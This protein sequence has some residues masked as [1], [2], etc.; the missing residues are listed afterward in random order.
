MKRDWDLIKDILEQVEA[1]TLSDY[2]RQ[3]KYL[4]SVENPD[5]F[6]GHIEILI[7][8]GI[9]KNCRVER[10]DS[11]KFEYWDFRGAYITMQGHDLLDA[12]RNKRLWNR[13]RKKALKAGISLSWEF[14]RIA[15]PIA[16]KELIT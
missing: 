8:A 3:N 9:I 10:S 6:L 4:D 7:E 16:I 1:N 5:D 11:G 13:I 15:I 12:I 2:I 14:I